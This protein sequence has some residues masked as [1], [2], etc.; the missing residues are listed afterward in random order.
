MS[1][2]QHRSND[3]LDADSGT[4]PLMSLLPFAVIN[5]KAHSGSKQDPAELLFERNVCIVLQD[6]SSAF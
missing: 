1:G 4:A 3:R 2:D 6:F 5:M